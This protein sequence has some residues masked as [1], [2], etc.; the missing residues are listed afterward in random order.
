MEK[1]G[2]EHVFSPFQIGNVEVRNRIE[3][4]PMVPCFD[5]TGFVSRETVEFYRR[6]ARG[7]AGLV[8]IGESSID[9]LYSKDHYGQLNLDNDGAIGGLS[10]LSEAVHTYGAKISIEI[11]HS[12]AGGACGLI[13][14]DKKPVAPSAT[15][16]IAGSNK[17]QS[18]QMDQD[19]INRIID[20]FASACYRCL[21]AGF[22]MVL[23]HGGHGWLLGQFASPYWNRR[24]DQYGG[25]IENRARFATEVLTEIRNRVGNKLAIEYRISAEELVP[26]GMQLDETIEF[27]KIIQNKIDLVHV[28]LG[29]MG[30]NPVY[31]LWMHPTYLPHAYILPW[32]E[33]I[34]KSVKVPVTCMGSITDLKMADGIIAEGKADMI[35]MARALLAD[36]ELPNKTLRGELEEIKPCTRCM[37]CVDWRTGYNNAPVRCAINPV[38]GREVELQRIKPAERKKKVVVVGGGPAGMQAA[39]TASERGHDVIL[40][41]KGKSLGGALG[42]AASPPFKADMKR[43][44]DWLVRQVM[45]SKVKVNLN[46]EAAAAGI[47]KE[48]ADVIIVAIGAAPFIPDIPGIKGNNVVLACDVDNGTAEVGNKVVVAGAGLVGCEA[49]LLLAQQGKNVVLIDMIREEDIAVD[50]GFQTQGHL[51]A[52]LRQHKVD[53]RPEVKLEEVSKKAVTVIDKGWVK[54]NLPADTLVIALGYCTRPEQVKS[55]ETLAKEVFT[56]GDCVKPGN[57]MS[58]IHSAFNAAIEI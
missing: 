49:A 24:K 43:Y 30:V 13:G 41:E 12:G 19:T 29:T 33:K 48:N 22:D 39:L 46:S 3:L 15:T 17:I 28:S 50:A 45:K 26:G 25:S 31:S 54:H 57:V 38:A 14:T 47:K 5:F 58:A 20:Q 56:I 18:V 8:T 21:R 1:T 52:L 7:G 6:F 11:N 34:K 51:V 55:F 16:F 2:F 44:L 4:A 32:T 42:Y 53:I 9:Y 36:P 35:A 37:Y 27:I 10:L 40:Y 23:L